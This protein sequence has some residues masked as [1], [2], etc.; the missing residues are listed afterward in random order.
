MP[1]P[2][3]IH[4]LFRYPFLDRVLQNEH[5]LAWA[6]KTSGAQSPRAN[7]DCSLTNSS[8]PDKL[9]LSGEA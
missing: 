9:R 1:S 8:T 6:V 7:V 5:D 4:V 3:R 2:A